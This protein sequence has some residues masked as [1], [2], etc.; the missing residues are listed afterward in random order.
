MKALILGAVAVVAVVAIACG[1]PE[2]NWKWAGWLFY[3]GAAVLMVVV[4]LAVY[5]LAQLME[6]HGEDD[7]QT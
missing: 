1:G 4:V 2:E 6:N 3:G 7:E 5:K